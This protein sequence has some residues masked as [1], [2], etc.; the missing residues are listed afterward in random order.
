M[1]TGMITDCATVEALDLDQAGLTLRVASSF[2]EL[3][4]GESIAVNGV[5][6]TVVEI[7][8][9]GFVCQVSPETLAVTMLDQL[10]VGAS[11]NLERALK[12]SDRLGGHWVTGHIDGMVTVASVQ[13]VGDYKQIDFTL[14]EQNNQAYLVA[15]GSV[16][17]NGV[18]LTVNDVTASGFNVMLIPHTLAETNLSQLMVGDSVNIEYDYLAKLVAK[19]V[20]HF[21]KEVSV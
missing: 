5:C 13:S 1:F 6:L 3:L 18:S 4:I 10:K 9:T 19:Q 11:L 21:S 12:A 16:A 7:S 17:I 15:K 2:S 14:S 8:E 20:V